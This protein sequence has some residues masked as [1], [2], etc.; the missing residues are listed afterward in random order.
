EAAR[1]RH[2]LARGLDAV[3]GDLRPPDPGV[4][5]QRAASNGEGA[6]RRGTGIDLWMGSMGRRLGPR[7]RHEDVRGVRAAQGA[8]AQV[9]LRAGPG[10]GG[11]QDTAGQ[12]VNDPAVRAGTTPTSFGSRRS[13]FETR[14]GARLLESR[15][16]VGHWNRWGPFLAERAW[17]TVREDYSASGDA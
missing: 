16:K 17:G 3:V 8:A 4:S 15:K 13:I 5:G 11:R 12:G 10:R 6:R 7:D 2:P 9:R 1:R 14:E